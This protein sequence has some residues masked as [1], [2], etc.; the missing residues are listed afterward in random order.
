MEPRAAMT[1]AAAGDW[2]AGYRGGS[3]WARW[4]DQDPVQS[5]TLPRAKLL[6]FIL[7]TVS[8]YPCKGV[9]GSA[10]VDEQELVFTGR[11]LAQ[12]HPEGENAAP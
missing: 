5:M 3:H 9:G 12:Y 8:A 2:N 6:D 10:D 11:R 1:S 4:Q 7:K